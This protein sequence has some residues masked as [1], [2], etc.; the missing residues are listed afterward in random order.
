M[1]YGW[2]RRNAEHED[3]GMILDFR[4]DREFQKQLDRVD[5]FLRRDGEPL[6]SI[7]SNFHD[8]GRTGRNALG[9]LRDYRPNN[10]PLRSCHPAPV[11][12][13]TAELYS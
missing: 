9:L 3:A 4:T 5:E 1:R 10:V 6:D 11:C 13:Y 7:L 2:R 12:G 8:A